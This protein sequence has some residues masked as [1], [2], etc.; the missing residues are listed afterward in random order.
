MNSII[1]LGNRFVTDDNVGIIVGYLLKKKYP[2]LNVY[3]CETDTFY[4]Q[5]VLYKNK[6]I[7]IVDAVSIGIETGSFIILPI[8]KLNA[9]SFLAHDSTL[10]LNTNTGFLFGIQAGNLDV[11]YGISYNIK[12]NLNL[13]ISEVYKLL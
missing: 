12:K 2:E 11:G 4:A 10:F 9:Q 1:C 7:V 13:Y 3:I 6:S 5:D 8:S